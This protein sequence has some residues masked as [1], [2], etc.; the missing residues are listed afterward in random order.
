MRR[1]F[2]PGFALRMN[3]RQPETH[4]LFPRCNSAVRH[5]G[6]KLSCSSEASAH[7]SGSRIPS[8]S[9]NDGPFYQIAAAATAPRITSVQGET[10]SMGKDSAAASH[11]AVKASIREAIVKLTDE[12]A[13]RQSSKP[14]SSAPGLGAPG[15]GADTAS[16]HA[17]AP[18]K[19][20]PARFRN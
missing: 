14:G 13:T 11:R 5:A 18:A 16:T 12:N 7:A 10:N 4:K 19:A 3:E 9:N 20:K 6:G 17:A 8:A 15:L 1:G 2:A